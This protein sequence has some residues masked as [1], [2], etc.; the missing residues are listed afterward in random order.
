MS[1]AIFGFIGVAIGALATG[2]VHL[3]LESRRERRELRRARRLIAAELHSIQL[4]LEILVRQRLTPMSAM[5]PRILPVEV[6]NESRGVLALL[7]DKEWELLPRIYDGVVKLRR[8]VLSVPPNS[9]LSPV[10]A[11]DA[12]DVVSVIRSARL[13]IG[14]KSLD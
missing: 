14:D 3:F 2:G 5:E 8:I 12:T 7:P 9:G 6:W 11:R 1:E 10:F 13:R 4:D